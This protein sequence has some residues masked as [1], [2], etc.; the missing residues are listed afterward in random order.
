MWRVNGAEQSK[1][2][3]VEI[4]CLKVASGATKVDR[5]GDKGKRALEWLLAGLE[6]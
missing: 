4:N 5:V 3:T 1:I 2:K 6:V